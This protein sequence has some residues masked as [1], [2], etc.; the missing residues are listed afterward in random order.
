MKKVDGIMALVQDYG[1][2][3]SAWERLPNEGRKS[4]LDEKS[5][6]IR[7]AIEALAQPAGEAPHPAVKSD[8]LVNAGALKMALNVLRRAGKDEAADELEKTAQPAGEAEPVG[9]YHGRCIID[10]GEH[11][12]HD[13]E[14]L[15]LI[16]AGSKLYTTPQQS[17]PLTD[18][19]S[20]TRS[21]SQTDHE[22]EAMRRYIKKITK[23]K[24]SAVGFL[25][26][27][28][29]IDGSGELAEQ[30]RNIEAAH[31]IK[32]GTE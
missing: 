13:I 15:K 10:C 30:Y 8:M 6:E 7:T 22:L 1:L 11:G 29:I 12:H 4:A 9:I 18:E 26:R 17:Q 24:D 28:G 14:M 3:Y 23:D 32:G 16:P 27:A 25:T 5:Q 2:Y 20:R 19:P 31:N 21:K